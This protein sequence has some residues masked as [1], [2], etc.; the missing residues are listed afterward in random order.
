MVDSFRAKIN[1]LKNSNFESLLSLFSGGS[2]FM[3]I[4]NTLKFVL[5]FL[6]VSLGSSLSSCK[7]ES[8]SDKLTIAAAS[9]TQFAI[10]EIISKFEDQ[11]GIDC[12]LILSS[13]GKLTAQILEGAPYDIF[14]SADEKYPYTIHENGQSAAVPKI[15]AEGKLVL[16][17]TA[18]DIAINLETLITDEISH[19]AI[20]N[21]KTAP[22]GRAANEVLN[23]IGILKDIED[24]LVYGESISQANRFVS[25]GAAEIGFTSKSVVLSSELQRV[26]NWIEIPSKMHTPLTQSAILIKS[27]QPKKEAKQFFDFL[28]S[29]E[30]QK[31]LKDFGYSVS[32]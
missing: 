30:A 28:F 29:T 8:A 16:W 27:K 26:A 19:I 20:A 2:C 5:F 4:S 12:E 18:Q 10:K 15:Y 14:L 32:E 3:H 17:S 21:P 31:V 1:N 25:S 11:H 22:Y 9:N 13:S 23:K 6:I 7:Q 24:K